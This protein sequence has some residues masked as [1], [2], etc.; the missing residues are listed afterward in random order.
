MRAFVV[1]MSL[2]GMLTVSGTVQAEHHAD[3]AAAQTLFERGRSAASRGDW[4]HACEAF[5]ESQRLDPGAGTLLNWA[6]CEV[7]LQRLASAWQHLSEAE[8]LLDPRDDRVAFVRAQLHKLS[9]RVPRLTLR[10]SPNMPAG[11]R[12]WRAQTELGAA[13]LGVALPMNPGSVELLVACA[14]HETRRSSVELREGEQLDITLEPGATLAANGAQPDTAAAPHAQAGGGLQRGLGLSLVALGAVGMGLGVASG[15]VVA[16]RERT[17]QAHCANNLC[18]ASGFRA[19]ES[20]ERWLTVNT[21]AWSV[22]AAA[23]VSGAVLLVLA[24]D[25]QR[26][27]SVQVLPGG[28]A[29][30]YGGRY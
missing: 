13:S 11:A 12:V 7:Q 10:L 19:A 3:A 29:L 30:V 21:V 4:P 24:H 9:P 22:G 8:Q 26:N 1:A 20:G 27:A 28:A 5:E 16:E 2:W 23:V 15:V 17:T 25:D 14:G 18:D 6:M